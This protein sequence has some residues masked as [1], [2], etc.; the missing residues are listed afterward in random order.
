L[1]SV[2]TINIQNE[3][4]SL[5]NV[6]YQQTLSQKRWVNSTKCCMKNF[7]KSGQLL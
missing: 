4:E 5:I 7:L 2:V 1:V 3:Y 6:R